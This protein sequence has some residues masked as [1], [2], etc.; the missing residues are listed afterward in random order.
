MYQ[1]LGRSGVLKEPSDKGRTL[2]LSLTHTT[3]LLAVQRYTRPYQSVCASTR[4]PI[5]LKTTRSDLGQTLGSVRA[6]PALNR[7]RA[8]TANHFESEPSRYGYARSR[9]S[10]SEV[11]LYCKHKVYEY[12]QALWTECACQVFDHGFI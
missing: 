11:V 12:L 3:H 10:W 7:D 4:R 6:V 8:A 5:I 1:A 2:P 9:P